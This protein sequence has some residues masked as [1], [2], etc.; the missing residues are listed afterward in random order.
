MLDDGLPYRAILERLAAVSP[1][2]TPSLQHSTNPSRQSV[3][4]ADPSP[5]PPLSPMNLSNWF[6]GGYQDW[7]RANLNP[8]PCPHRSTAPTLQHSVPPPNGAN[9]QPTAAIK[10]LV[11]YSEALTMLGFPP[12]RAGLRCSRLRLQ[13]STS[14]PNGRSGGAG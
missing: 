11:L 13:V 5:R 10:G 1:I 12:P 3:A 14:Q 2:A 6:H 7:R 9:P 4:T 8:A